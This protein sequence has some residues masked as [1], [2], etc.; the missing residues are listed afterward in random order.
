M[1]RI[2]EIEYAGCSTLIV[3]FSPPGSFEKWVQG[4]YKK[5]F[6]FKKVKRKLKELQGKNN[7]LK[8]KI[9]LSKYEYN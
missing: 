5:S 7:Y 9:H 3:S 4:Y 1:A 2:N 8:I 6:E